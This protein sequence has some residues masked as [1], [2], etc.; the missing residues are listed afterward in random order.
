MAEKK[1]TGEHDSTSTAVMKV[2]CSRVPV[3]NMSGYSLR[4]RERRRTCIRSEQMVRTYLT[5]IAYLECCRASSISRSSIWARRAAASSAAASPAG[6]ST[7]SASAS[8]SWSPWSAGAPRRGWRRRGGT[9]AGTAG[10]APPPPPAAAASAAAGASRRLRISSSMSR[11]GSVSRAWRKN[12]SSVLRPARAPESSVDQEG[13]F[14]S[15]WEH[16]SFSKSSMSLRSRGRVVSM[17]MT[18][19]AAAFS[20]HSL[21]SAGKV[22]VGVWP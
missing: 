3:T 17:S 20:S 10:T 5:R 15:C 6:A 19:P 9:G 22:N 7:A 14:A 4:M 13:S 1:S 8:C 16:A 21:R 2:Q 12:G 18:S 11:Q